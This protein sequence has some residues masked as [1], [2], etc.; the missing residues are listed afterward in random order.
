MQSNGKCIG[1]EN[2]QPGS[3]VLERKERKINFTTQPGMF[4]YHLPFPTAKHLPP[5]VI[6]Q[7]AGV[8][9]EYKG[10]ILDVVAV[11]KKYGVIE[12]R[13]TGSSN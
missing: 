7:I 10:E 2:K 8:T 11:L 9:N 4:L 6:M 12:F 1:K 13:K 5:S 3:V